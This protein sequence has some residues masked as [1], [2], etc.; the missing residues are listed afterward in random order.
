LIALVCAGIAVFAVRASAPWDLLD[1]DQIRP[2]AYALDAVVHGNWVIQTDFK[3]DVASKP[4]VYTWC[5]AALS[6]PLGR[7]SKL[8]LYLP[9]GFAITATALLAGWLAGRRYGAR[10]GLLAGL[11]ILISP[12]GMKH[13]ALARTDAVFALTTSLAG[14]LGLLAWE[15]KRSWVWF[16]L[17][18]AIAT[19]TKGPLGAAIGSA[20]LLAAVWERRTGHV[21][22][23]TSGHMIGLSVFLV[24]TVGWF[25]LAYLQLGGRLIDKMI[26]RELLGHAVRSDGGGAFPGSSFAVPS[27]YFLARFA[28]WSIPVVFGIVRV[29]RGEDG[30][31]DQRRASRYLVCW[32]LVGLA[33]FSIAPHQR[34]DHLLPIL[35]PAAVLGGRELSRWCGAWSDRKFNAWAVFAFGIALAAGVYWY[36]FERR[37]DPVIERLGHAR[38]LAAEIQTLGIDQGDLIFA[39]GT[40]AIQVLLG[41]K[42][43]RMTEERAIEAVAAE[44]TRV[45]VARHAAQITERAALIGVELRSTA[46]FPDADASYSLL[47][48]EKPATDRP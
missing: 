25:Y 4:P 29:F 45:I 30:D 46:R 1:N 27:L 7:V 19:L 31:N 44:P 18:C 35:L 41:T 23:R 21:G 33:V 26:G 39:P 20:G 15:G 5:V 22:A 2:A 34:A 8:T 43:D 48:T 24:L 11:A 16:Y 14:V 3:D 36:H 17:A 38:E 42:I 9:C 13:M 32:F 28:P 40:S 12:L 10:A 6:A 37:D 47:Q